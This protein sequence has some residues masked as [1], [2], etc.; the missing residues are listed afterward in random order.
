MQSKPK[1]LEPHEIKELAKR[2]L[3]GKFNVRDAALIAF[4]G[5]SYL[6]LLDLSLIRVRI[7]LRKVGR[8]TSKRL[9]L[10]NLTQ[11]ENRKF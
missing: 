6:T 9:S 8:Y 11:M 5:M 3:Q 10:L 7:C 4:S 2:H 1:F